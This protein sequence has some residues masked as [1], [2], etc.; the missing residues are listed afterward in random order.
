MYETLLYI[1]TH[2]DHY[3]FHTDR[4]RLLKRELQQ[5]TTLPHEKQEEAAQEQRLLQRFRLLFANNPFLERKVCVANCAE[6]DASRSEITG[7]AAEGYFDTHGKCLTFRPK[8]SQQGGGAAEVLTDE[9]ISKFVQAKRCEAESAQTLFVEESKAAVQNK[10]AQFDYI[11]RKSSSISGKKVKSPTLLAVIIILIFYAVAVKY[12]FFECHLIYAIQTFGTEI[13]SLPSY[14]RSMLLVAMVVLLVAVVR[15]PMYVN[16]II[17]GVYRA[18]VRW[19]FHRAETKQKSMEKKVQNEWKPAEWFER[20][21]QA[22]QQDR[23]LIEST[24]D[25]PLDRLQTTAILREKQE[26]ILF[27]DSLFPKRPWKRYKAEGE[28]RRILLPIILIVIMCVLD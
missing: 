21:G 11:L 27:D 3:H 18:A 22:L 9:A 4:A 14:Y 13:L 8:S 6:K 7:A 24:C 5:W 2:L 25:V 20:Y 16:M 15:L 19:R 26:L 12:V 28:R 1:A 23:S 17:K 10:K